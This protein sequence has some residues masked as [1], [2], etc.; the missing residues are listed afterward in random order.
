MLKVLIRK[1]NIDQRGLELK[2]RMARRLLTCAL[3]YCTI[4]LSTLSL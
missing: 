2:T 4:N 3:P 1:K